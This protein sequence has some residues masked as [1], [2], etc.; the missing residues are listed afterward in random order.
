MVLAAVTP[1]SRTDPDVC[2]ST[3]YVTFSHMMSRSVTLVTV[4]SVGLAYIFRV[5]MQLARYNHKH[6]I[7]LISSMHILARAVMCKLHAQCN[8]HCVML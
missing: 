1:K 6:W 7:D 3:L 4:T 5:R 2:C 8:I